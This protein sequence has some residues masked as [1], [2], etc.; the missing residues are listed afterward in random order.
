MLSRLREG[1]S[2]DHAIS[3]QLTVEVHVSFAVY[4]MELGKAFYQVFRCSVL[5]QL[6]PHYCLQY[7]H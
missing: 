4:K 2:I 1:R 7:V 3:H 6:I 5:I